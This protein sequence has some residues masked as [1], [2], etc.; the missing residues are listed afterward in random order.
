MEKR[1]LTNLERKIARRA[2]A[3]ASIATAVGAA[4]ALYGMSNDTR[5]GVSQGTFETVEC[6][7]LNNLADVIKDPEAGRIEVENASYNAALTYMFGADTDG[8][9][10]VDMGNISEDPHSEAAYAAVVKAG[11]FGDELPLFGELSEQER[12]EAA[13]PYLVDLTGIIDQTC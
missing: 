12:Q 13:A 4:I 1:P 6:S 2:T 3:T 8:D 5:I 9:G 7:N 10:K 11:E